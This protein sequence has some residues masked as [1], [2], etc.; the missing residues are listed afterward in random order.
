MAAVADKPQL[1]L[2]DQLVGDE[3]LKAQLDEWGRAKIDLIKPRERFIQI[4]KQVMGAIAGMKLPD[5]TYRCGAFVIAIKT[6]EPR[7]VSFERTSTT[8]IRIKPQKDD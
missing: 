3:D 6:G 7:Q 2:L 4:N 8:S 5:G 1:G